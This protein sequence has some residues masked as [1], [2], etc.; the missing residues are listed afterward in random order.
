[1]NIYV[2]SKTDDA[3]L[4][5]ER[6]VNEQNSGTWYQRMVRKRAKDMVTK[7]I[8]YNYNP[9][10]KRLEM[11]LKPDFIARASMI[12]GKAEFKRKVELGI[13][14]KLYDMDLEENEFEVE[15]DG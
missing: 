15:F 9:D 10:K 2:I 13:K 4:A 12:Y 5:F 3:A 1:M 6:L 14:N 7:M 8:V 11:E